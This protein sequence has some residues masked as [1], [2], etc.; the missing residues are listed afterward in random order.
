MPPKK[1]SGAQ[2]KALRARKTAALKVNTSD[3]S[4]FLLPKK[5]CTTEVNT[6][7]SP[8]HSDIS[9]SSST[10]DEGEQRKNIKLEFN[11]NHEN[12]LNEENRQNDE[13]QTNIEVDFNNPTT[14]QVNNYTIT[15]YVEHGPIRCDDIGR[16]PPTNNRRFEKR[17]FTNI[18]KNGERI[19]RNWLMYCKDLDSLFCFPCKL[20]NDTNNNNSWT[21]GFNDWKHLN[22]MV[23][24][25]ENSISH[26]ENYVKLKAFEKRLKMGGCID[27][28]L[29]KT[30]ENEKNKWRH[31]LKVIIDAI[32]HCIKNNDAL[33]GTSEIIGHPNCGRFLNT[34]ELISHYDNVIK[35]HI[36]T[37]NKGQL[38]YFSP[39]IQN[40]LISLAATKVRRHI[41]QDIKDAKYFSILFD[42]TTDVAHQEQLVQIIRYVHIDGNR[43]CSIKES[44]ID[45]INT[46]EK[47]GEGLTKEILE[48]LVADCLDIKNVRGQSYDN[49][50]NMAGIYKGVQ[51]RILMLNNNAKFIPCTAHSLNLVGVHAA[52]VIPQMETFF[53]TVQQIYNFFVGSSSR[54]ELLKT[55]VNLTLKGFCD[56]RWSSKANAVHSLTSQLGKIIKI[57]RELKE[58]SLVNLITT[59]EFIIYLNFWNILLGKIN[60]IN[61]SLQ[62]KQ[63]DISRGS[64]MIQGLL[65]EVKAYRENFF[66][67]LMELSKTEANKIGIEAE[68]H[69]SRK[70]KKPKM[71]GELASDEAHLLDANAKLRIGLIQVLDAIIIQIE[72]RFVALTEVADDFSFLNG[73]LIQNMTINNLKKSATDLAIKYPF[74]LNADEFSMEIESFK[75]QSNIIL[76]NFIEMGPLQILNGL[77]DLTIENIYP[78][79]Q[80]A[81]RIFLSLPVTTATCERSFS[82][83]KL[84]KSYLRS[85]LGQER[86]SNMSILA[87][88]KQVTCTL[89]Y[90]ELVDMFAEV[91][92][93]KTRF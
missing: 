60:R 13:L 27:D 3:I 31:I 51:A 73:S 56:T 10:D 41:L 7:V 80:T 6:A 75:Y 30:I 38:S 92:S 22:P 36:E 58:S 18:K 23:P 14:W 70:R 21:T 26:R 88:E 84:I 28:E 66:T 9:D 71:S 83:L 39:G 63:L 16:Y 19:F 25:H 4:K 17:W 1:L 29:L 86:L 32:L 81:L 11:Q 5:L 65:N 79:L 69:E 2:N 12:E 59:Y 49:G 20:F 52:E 87:I 74:D 72:K 15:M 33:R 34:I 64:R 40:E 24:R 43:Q 77:H 89:D 62:E 42:C 37:H 82:K 53:A 57:L 8:S 48:K 50:A 35:T 90:S 91:K 45:F 76:E 47:T 44:F 46:R 67:P 55:E 54:W 61:K 93:R 68:L 78:N 85:S